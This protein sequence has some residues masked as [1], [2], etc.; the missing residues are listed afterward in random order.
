MHGSLLYDV[1]LF[2]ANSLKHVVWMVQDTLGQPVLAH[3]FL[4]GNRIESEC[5][6][7]LVWKESTYQ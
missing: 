6:W 3:T 1:E 7:N 2:A 4:F 5:K